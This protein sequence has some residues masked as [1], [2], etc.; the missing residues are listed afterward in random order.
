MIRIH[1]TADDPLFDGKETFEGYAL[2]RN[3]VRPPGTFRVL[4]VSDGGIQAM[5][6]PGRPLYGVMFHPEVRNEWVV[7]RFLRI[8]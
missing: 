7:E 3:S 8:P 6:H 4:A 5:R 1:R 2:H